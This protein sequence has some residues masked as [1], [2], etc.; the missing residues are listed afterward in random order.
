MKVRRLLDAEREQACGSGLRRIDFAWLVE[1]GVP[2]HRTAWRVPGPGRVD[3]IL[4]DAVVFGRRGRFEFSRFLRHDELERIVAY[5]LL[6][7]D[8]G[9]A[10]V[11]V[12]AWHPRSNRV[13]TW[14]GRAALLGDDALY[15]AP[16]DDPLVIHPDPLAWLAGDRRGA[17]IV[18]ERLA[19]PILLEAGSIQAADLAHGQRL[20]AMLE[21]VRLP[22]ISVP[23]S[24]V[25]SIA[26]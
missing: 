23:A 5:T 6:V 16:A 4:R 24:S 26:A 9:G 18:D 17:V 21:Q 10:P 3:M 22:K 11:D 20:K 13:A 12:V 14:L 2:G 1:G 19:R 8:A 7:R 15:P 25:R